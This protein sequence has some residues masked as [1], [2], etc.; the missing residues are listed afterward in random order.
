M[1]SI[2]LANVSIGLYDKTVAPLVTASM[3]VVGALIGTDVRLSCSVESHP[4]SINYWIKGRH[5]EHNT[6]L[7]RYNK[8]QVIIKTSTSN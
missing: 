8:F 5:Q 2:R 4:P 6:I 7:P 1:Q 3:N